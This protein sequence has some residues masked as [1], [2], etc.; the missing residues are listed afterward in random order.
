MWRYPSALTIPGSPPRTMVETRLVGQQDCEGPELLVVGK[1]LLTPVS[2]NRAEIRTPGEQCARAPPPKPIPLRLAPVKPTPSPL[3]PPRPAPFRPAPLRT[4][5]GT[6]VPS[7]TQVPFRG[8]TPSVV[9]LKAT[10]GRTGLPT[11]QQEQPFW[12]VRQ[13]PLVPRPPI[14]RAQDRSVHWVSDWR[15]PDTNSLSSL[16]PSDLENEDPD[17]RGQ[18]AE[19][20]CIHKT[21]HL[22]PINDLGPKEAT[23][24][25]LRAAEK[26]RKARDPRKG[27]GPRRKVVFKD[28]LLVQDESEVSQAK[29]TIKSENM[30][31]NCSKIPLK[32]QQLVPTIVRPVELLEN[33]IVTPELEELLE[34]IRAIPEKKKSHATIMVENMRRQ[35]MKKRALAWVV[36]RE[37]EDSAVPIDEIPES[38]RFFT[39]WLTT[40]S[41]Y[42][43]SLPN[44]TPQQDEEGYLEFLVQGKPV[45]QPHPPK[46]P[47]PTSIDTK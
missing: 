3:A 38:Q 44:Q 26:S 11:S 33:E 34:A 20:T 15:A 45:L 17:S 2:I 4:P 12:I 22:P 31:N 7:M 25:D 47:K 27:V 6:N 14:C 19:N 37:R 30:Q 40:R 10:P 18:F 5:L 32:R 13:A 46:T 8:L 39:H 35:E 23:E 28:D 42:P 29:P 41:N 36:A 1:G 9:P 43:K 16:T 21:S 24:A